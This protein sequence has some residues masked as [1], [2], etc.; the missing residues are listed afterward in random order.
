MFGESADIKTAEALK[1]PVPEA[2]F[3][4]VSTKASEF[5]KEMVDALAERADKVR[6]HKVRPEVDNMLNITNDGRKLALDQRIANPLLP[7]DE[8]SKVNKCVENVFDIWEKTTDKKSAYKAKAYIKR[9]TGKGN[10]FYT[11]LRYRCTK[12]DAFYK[13]TQRR[14]QSAAWL[15]Q[16]NGNGYKLSAKTESSAPS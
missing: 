9:Y 7:D 3:H 15:Y 8:N 13:G 12:T 5:Q 1:L 14:G 4:I 11:R 16:Q 10:S 2:E 6:K